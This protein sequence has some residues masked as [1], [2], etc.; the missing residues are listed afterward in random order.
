MTREPKRDGAPAR[1]DRPRVLIIDDDPDFG[2]DLEALLAPDFI[3]RCA[4]SGEEGLGAVAADAPDAIVLDLMLEGG[5]NGLEILAALRG[6]HPAIPVIMATAHPSAE[7][8][9]AALRGGA[10][11]YLHKAA[12]RSE[13]AAKLKRAVDVAATSRERDRLR[14]D[15][16]AGAGAGTFLFSSPRLR[17]LERQVDRFA[18]AGQA[19]VLIT[20]ETGTGKTLL[21]REIHR[22]SQRASEPFLQVNM[23]AIAPGTAVSELFGHL[24]GAFTGAVAHRRGHFEAVG[25]GTLCLDEIGD[26][27]LETQ[28]L[29]LQA[30]EEHQILPLGSSTPR[31]VHARVLAATNRDLEAMVTQGAFRQD[32]LSRLSALAVHVPPL[33]EHVED[34]PDLARYFLGRHA[35]DLGLPSARL[36]PA[37]LDLLQRS[38]WRPDNVR[39]LRV[40]LLRALVLSEKPGHIDA[41]ALDL[42]PARREPAGFDYAAAKERAVREFQRGFLRHA[43]QA[44]GGSATHPRPEEIRRVA[45]LAGIPPHTVRRILKE[46]GPPPPPTGEVEAAES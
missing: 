29:L 16:H 32:L 31:P 5:R 27:P 43:F 28:G 30:I 17:A 10:L 44:V 25:H 40:A 46:L 45:E 33:R 20:G 2:P 21:A 22:R 8:E 36:T 6:A 37:A 26:L 13:V 24:R 11:Y 42:P 3:C 4:L 18:A 19:P 7:T 38:D 15:L 12:G 9:A 39:G 1:P 34:I 41:A 23:G 35:A 14:R